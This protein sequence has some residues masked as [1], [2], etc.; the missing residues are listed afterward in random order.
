MASPKSQTLR[1]LNIH[2]PWVDILQTLGLPAAGQALPAKTHCPLCQGRRFSLYQDNIAGGAWG[3]CFDCRW[4]GDLIELAATVWDLSVAETV[5]RLVQQG[6]PI[7]QRKH[8]REAVAAYQTHCHDQR[9]RLWSLWAEAQR[10]YIQIPS[11]SLNNLL[12][13][14]GL[15]HDFSR[16]RTAAGPA[17]YMGYV[18]YNTAHRAIYPGRP[19]GKSHVRLFAGKGHFGHQDLLV[20]PY[21][22]PPGQIAAFEFAGRYGD[23]QDWC[24]QPSH[25]ANSRGREGGLAGLEPALDTGGRHVIAVRDPYVMLQMQMRHFRASLR[26][27][28]VVTWHDCPLAVTRSAWEALEG[29]HLVFWTPTVDAETILQCHHTGGQM[30]LVGPRDGCRDSIRRFLHRRCPADLLRLLIQRAKPWQDVVRRWLEQ[31]GEQQAVELVR[32][33]DAHGED[34]IELLR[35]LHPRLDRHPKLSIRTVHIGET[36]YTERQGRLYHRRRTSRETLVLGGLVRIDHLVRRRHQLEYCGRLIIDGEEIPLRW[37]GEED[38]PQFRRY[39]VSLAASRGHRLAHSHH[40]RPLEAALAFQEPKVLQGR[41]RIGWNGSRFVFRHYSISAGQF[42]R[43]LPYL[44][45]EGTPGPQQ[46]VP[47]LYQ[48]TAKLLEQEGTE[49]EFFWATVVSLLSIVLG[50]LA[51]RPVVPLLFSGISQVGHLETLLSRLGVDRRVFRRSRNLGHNE[52]APHSYPHHWP[53]YMSRIAE[54]RAPLIHRWLLNT[55]IRGSCVIV[56]P[57]NAFVL[58]LHDEFHTLHCP[59]PLRAGMLFRLP[60]EHVL[61]DYLRHASRQPGSFPAAS[62]WWEQVRQDIAAWLAGRGLASQALARCH[63]WM[64]FSGQPDVI[65]HVLLLLYG[66][67]AELPYDPSGLCVSHETLRQAILKRSLLVPDLSAY[68]DPL[69][70]SRQELEQLRVT[71]HANLGRLP[72]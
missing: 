18:P 30:A 44:L 19:R 58:L 70:L 24:Y 20:I 9:R 23:P 28:P 53:V 67:G 71:D 56:E 3:Y 32:Q 54:S 47:R 65:R 11:H 29:R 36:I 26:P 15:T 17:R 66:S 37:Q 49:A 31:T 4:S 22:H 64:H 21:F 40:G 52:L 38:S 68:P 45:P 8:N 14:L 12:I 41:R 39:L 48:N 2:V 55:R 10:N 60:M 43:H 42:H 1:A 33:M 34:G 5:D 6:F 57:L 50:P 7:P 59:W 51:G 13:H 25:V 46:L 63:R 62:S 72:G 35:D 27:L 61:P 16:E 69:R